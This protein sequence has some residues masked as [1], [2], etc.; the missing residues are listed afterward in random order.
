M[1][2]HFLLDSGTYTG[3]MCPAGAS[4]VSRSFSGSITPVNVWATNKVRRARASLVRSAILA[5]APG[6]D[7]EGEH[8]GRGRIV[9]HRESLLELDLADPM[10]ADQASTELL[11]GEAQEA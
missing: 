5:V 8:D 10:I 6:R 7:S 11:D 4:T 3:V 1:T 9:E 2:G